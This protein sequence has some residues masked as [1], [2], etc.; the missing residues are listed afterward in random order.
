MNSPGGSAAA[1]NIS[2][3]QLPFDMAVAVPLA[4][5]TQVGWAIAIGNFRYGFRSRKVQLVMP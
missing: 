3:A 5:L 2:L 1:N 4:A